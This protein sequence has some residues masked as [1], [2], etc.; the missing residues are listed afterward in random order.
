M[1][2]DRSATSVLRD[3]AE[4]RIT[5]EELV[6]ASLDMIDRTD[7]VVRAFLLVRREQAL[8]EARQID[9]RRRRGEKLGVLA[10]LPIAVKDVLCTRGE[11]TTCG[12]RMLAQ[13]RPPY[14]ATVVQRLRA[15]DG[16]LIGKTNLDEFAMGSSTENSAFFPTRNPWDPT[17]VPGGS[18]GG[19]AACLAARQVPLAVGTDTGG[20]IRQPAAF[21]GVVG[22]KPTYGRVSRY[23][24]VAYASSLDQAGPMART[25]ED[26]ARLLS[27]LAGPDRRDST[28]APVP[29][30]AY[31]EGL[32][33][34]LGPMRI[35]LIREH[36]REGLRSSV[37]TAIERAIAVFVR[38]GA[39]L[40]EISMPHARYGIAA[41]YVL[42]PCEASSNLAR[43]DGMHYGL[44]SQESRAVE[45]SGAKKHGAEPASDSP[46]VRLYR[47][48]RS[49]GFGLEVKRRIM[50]G[51][52]ALS[53]GYQDR[54][55]VK[56]LRVRRLIR[57]DYEA[58]F[59]QVDV[60]VGPTTPSTAFR[61]GEKL[62]DPLAMYLEDLFTVGANLAGVPAIS[63]PCGFDENG[64]PIGMQLQAPWFCE[65]RLLQL[66]Y[67]YQQHT[68]WHERRP[69]L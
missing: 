46:L 57:A 16:V 55:Y 39:E 35:G 29:A 5:S 69:A 45:S 60:L 7:Q 14:D 44:R 21:C 2:W 27:V 52:F 30:E 23:G 15:A 13:F 49:Q 9:Q 6:R 38:L 68:D 24:L 58:A 63:I 26:V 41:Y 25:A 33:A 11:P 62:A 56:A 54:Y 48:T 3:L 10:G 12:S 17:R 32:E 40:V 4:G 42:A 43:Y 31:H 20:S 34:P 47:T 59:R 1:W 18:S 50:L 64:L 51:T 61:L 36:F 22:L 66:A 67:H 65:K 28:C 8:A 37:V 53:A 19:S